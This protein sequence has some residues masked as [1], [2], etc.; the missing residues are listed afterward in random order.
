MV[1]FGTIG[2]LTR[3][4][5]LSSEELALYRAILAS[6]FLIS[7]LALKGKLNKKLIPGK[8]ILLPLFL[9]GA[10]MGFN[11]IFLFQAYRYTSISAATLSY[12][13]APSVV[14]LAS[15]FL[16]GEKLT[17][18]KTISFIVSTIGVLLVIGW[19][20]RSGGNDAKGILF[21]LAAA[22]LYAF[23]IISNKRIEGIG[24]I[25][26]TLLQFL[27]A[28]VVLLP[29][30]LLVSGINITNIGGGQWGL[31]LLLGLFHT[32]ITY[33]LYFTSLPRLKGGE[34]SILSY[35]DPLTAMIVSAILLN[36]PTSALQISG[37]ILILGSTLYSQL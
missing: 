35:L 19:G 6:L 28:I 23:V 25:E 18:K 22:V 10:A 13:F 8:R 1:I 33:S 16:L 34:I 37:G 2:L 9:S 21:G 12:Y 29:Y 5:G 30:T 7:Y 4:I 15:H 26:R 36:E 14:L 31:L 11:W 27:S 32:G 24:G 17:R 20:G 3:S